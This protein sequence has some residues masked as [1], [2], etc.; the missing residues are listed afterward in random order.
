MKRRS[1]TFGAA[2]AALLGGCGTPAPAVDPA[3]DAPARPARRT[4][5]RPGPADY[6]QALAAWR[7]PEDIN[8]WIGEHF[9]YDDDRALDLSESRRAA[10]AAPPIHEPQAFFLRPSGICVDL[11]RFAVE[12]LAAVAPELKP[13]YLMLEFSPAMRAGQVLRLHWLAAFERDGALHV[14]GDSKFP[15]RIAGPYASL[16]GFVREYSGLRQREIV[17][18]REAGSF[19]RR[20]RTE[21]RRREPAA[22]A[23]GTPAPEALRR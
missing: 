10:G 16:E 4:P 19:R 7:R 20:L 12:T 1:I 3:S 21:Q 6:A 18:F 15:G 17:S 22:G 11:A 9:D 14:F 8:A 13:R 23:E 5:A 2:G